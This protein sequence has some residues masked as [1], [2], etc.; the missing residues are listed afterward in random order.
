[1]FHCKLP[2]WRKLGK[3][4]NKEALISYFVARSVISPVIGLGIVHRK[5]VLPTIIPTIR[6]VDQ[7]VAVTVAAQTI[8]AIDVVNQVSYINATA[9]PALYPS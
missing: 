7:R 6:E 2:D 1:M 3:I 5:G 4:P 9:I 8:H